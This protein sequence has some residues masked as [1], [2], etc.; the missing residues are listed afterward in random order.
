MRY[1]SL[2]I[3]LLCVGFIPSLWAKN[4]A[5]IYGTQ[6]HYSMG[7]HD[8]IVEQES[9]HT[10][11]IDGNIKVEH[12]TDSDIYLSGVLDVF[13]DADVDKLDPDHIPVWFKSDYVASGSFYRVA[14]EFFFGWQVDLQGKRNT[15]S[16]IEKQGK[17]FPAMTINYQSQAT[18][19]QLKMGSGYYYLEIDDDVPRT[20]GY[21]RGDFGNGEFAYTIM[22]GLGF[23]FTPKFMMQFAA[24]TWNDGDKWLEDQYRFLFSYQTQVWK[25]N[26]QWQLDIERTK[27][28]LVH[29]AKGNERFPDYV[30]ILPWDSDTL[31]RFSLVVPW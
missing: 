17:L 3:T 4:T 25:K 7:I 10:F 12:L 26:S 9:S 16:S 24:Q 29:Y 6:W 23:E 1:L 19:A 11:G 18:Q 15:V 13:I 30:P 27:Y 28:N 22:G 31:V 20:R 5:D 2:P 8:F 14:P 21:E